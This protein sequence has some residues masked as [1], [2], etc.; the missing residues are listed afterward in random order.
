MSFKEGG[1]GEEE[2][3]YFHIS[4]S[5]DEVNWVLRMLVLS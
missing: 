1:G 3:S 4:A 5:L 2:G